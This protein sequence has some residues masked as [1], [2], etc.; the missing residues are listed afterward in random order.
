M[1]QFDVTLA[2]A[3]TNGTV[4]TN[5][6]QL[7]AGTVKLA[8]SDDPNVNGQS[9]PTSQVTRI[10]RACRSLGAYFDVDKVSADLDG[11]PLVLLAGERLRYTIT[12]GTSARAVYRRDVARC[13]AREHDLRRGQHHTERR[14]RADG[15][16]G[17]SP[18]SAG[19]ALSAPRNP[20]PGVMRADS[21]PTPRT[22]R[23]C[24]SCGSIPTSSTAR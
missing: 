21:T 7:L 9:D 13:G 15:A 22:S 12:H 5:Q 1:I 10:R 14:R 17:P 6:A 3:I 16:G 2:S 20:T 4:V 18:L 24:S 8:D 19:I 23:P 11:D